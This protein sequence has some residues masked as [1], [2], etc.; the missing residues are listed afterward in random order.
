MKIVQCPNPDCKAELALSAERQPK[1]GRC[2]QELTGEELPPKR[3]ATSPRGPGFWRR[4][5]GSRYSQLRERKPAMA[6][7]VRKP[8][9]YSEN[10]KGK[11]DRLAKQAWGSREDIATR[12]LIFDLKNLEEG[13]H[14]SIVTQLLRHVDR[15]A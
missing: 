13:N 3:L 6:R 12:A 10:L 15:V 1:C 7:A 14:Q 2:G 4:I 9:I 5:F 11:V 8:T